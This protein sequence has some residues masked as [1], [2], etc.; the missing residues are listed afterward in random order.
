[1]AEL[2]EGPVVGALGGVD[3]ELD[4]AELVMVEAVDETDRAVVIAGGTGVVQSDIGLVEGI[5]PDLFLDAAVTP[6]HPL[7]VDDGVHEVALDGS[8]GSEFRVVFGLE[9]FEGG[10]IFAADRQGFGMK[11]GLEG[12]HAGDGLAGLAAGA[13]G[14]LRIT[15]IREELLFG[16]H[17]QKCAGHGPALHRIYHAGGMESEIQTWK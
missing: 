6:E 8:G 16:C 4:A 10:G 7:V 5:G 3:A 1:L 2:F 15:T 17:K 12:V 11:A 13:G 9:G 14:M